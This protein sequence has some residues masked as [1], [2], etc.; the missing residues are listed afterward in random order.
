VPWRSTRPESDATLAGQAAPLTFPSITKED[1]KPMPLPVTETMRPGQAARRLLDPAPEPKS[2]ASETIVSQR[3]NTLQVPKVTLGRPPQPGPGAKPRQTGRFNP[4][5]TI[6]GLS[7][8]TIL[9]AI[10]AIVLGIIG[11]ALIIAA[12][13]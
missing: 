13:Q 4:A 9:L 1:S 8:E 7:R 10:G 6:A 12:L 3:G 2:T 11:F 5:A